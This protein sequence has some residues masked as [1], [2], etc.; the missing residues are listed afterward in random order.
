MILKQ[1]LSKLL[2]FSAVFLFC[3]TI[4]A[5]DGSYKEMK[6]EHFSILFPP[7]AEKSAH[8]V[9]QMG[10]MSYLRM[11]NIVSYTPAY[12]LSLYLSLNDGDI[13][14]YPE[15]KI[16]SLSGDLQDAKERLD[17]IMAEFVV[18]S[19]YG[20][21]KSGYYSPGAS[22]FQPGPWFRK[23]LAFYGGDHFDEEL[24][25]TKVL[26]A[27]SRKF[28]LNA[29]RGGGRDALELGGSLCYYIEHHYSSGTLRFFIRN[30][31]DGSSPA[32]AAEEALGAGKDAIEKEWFLYYNGQTGGHSLK[33]KALKND[34]FLI[35]IR[36][37]NPGVKAYYSPHLKRLYLS[38]SAGLRPLF[39]SVSQDSHGLP[40]NVTFS[41][42]GHF[43]SYVAVGRGGA[44]YLCLYDTRLNT[45]LYKSYMPFYQVREPQWSSQK[46]GWFF[47][48]V[49]RKA[50]DIFFYAPQSQE[51]TQYTRDRFIEKSP[52]FTDNTLY[53]L[54]NRNSLNNFLHRRFYLFK[55]TGSD[56]LS[57]KIGVNPV[58]STLAQGQGGFI[59]SAVLIKKSSQEF[60]QGFE[61]YDT[62]SVQHS[63]A[64]DTGIP[65]HS[66]L[67]KE[68]E[69]LF[70]LTRDNG[71]LSRRYDPDFS[72]EHSLYYTQD[73]ALL[74]SGA[75]IDYQKVS[76]SRYRE[77][78]F[79]P[80]ISG[81]SAYTG[82][83]GA[84]VLGLRAD[85]YELFT[86]DHLSGNLFLSYDKDDY[87]WQPGFAMLYESALVSP[88]LF[89]LNGY[90]K[91]L[92]LSGEYV[93]SFGDGVPDRSSSYLYG[94]GGGVSRQY[95][96][97]LEHTLQVTGVSFSQYREEERYKTNEYLSVKAVM[98]FL[99]LSEDPILGYREGLFAS[100]TGNSFFISGK[101]LGLLTLSGGY[102]RSYF[103][104]LYTSLTASYTHPLR[105]SREF[106]VLRPYSTSW[107]LKDD[108]FSE[109]GS[110]RLDA[111]MALNLS[112]NIRPLNINLGH[113]G[114]GAKLIM[115]SES[116]NSRDGGQAAYGGLF[117]KAGSDALFLSLDSM[118]NLCEPKHLPNVMLSAGVSF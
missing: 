28:R 20:D 40:S 65:S 101:R 105:T 104:T 85:K 15:R 47:V 81:Y 100:L 112:K 68:G 54:S 23:L 51:L 19:L 76:I 113:L 10:E 6:S 89:S 70:T 37:S 82:P 117:I 26:A 36:S 3:S 61:R 46:K 33:G 78:R 74:H 30:I 115:I 22:V 60:T 4:A 58:V 71:Y 75:L 95:S 27:D 87:R 1:L 67:Y 91:P 38:T 108:E 53:Y 32:K 8:V 99:P 34:P 2:L 56:G 63:L 50:T 118:W 90:K 107:F 110:A 35:T 116:L 66:I 93:P 44:L 17:R 21:T 9:L 106:R 45:R 97:R 5:L 83:A 109:N 43:L 42:N 11:S 55:Q 16:L 31:L 59:Y 7:S 88:S 86:K 12:P 77:K 57:E 25:D 73:A 72:G 14:I 94:V 29:I 24:F 48:G 41:E 111:L 52:L 96:N 69:Y 79:L 102:G 62:K 64:V 84:L 114:A 49:D 39:E 80:R 92:Y 18:Y 13:S 103:T 98:S